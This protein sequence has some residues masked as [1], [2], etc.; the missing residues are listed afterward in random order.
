VT[1]DLA[2]PGL[3]GLPVGRRRLLGRA[4]LLLLSRALGVLLGVVTTVLIAKQLG[5]P[6]FGTFALGLVLL[7]L[8]GTITD[9][10]LSALIVR[11]SDRRPDLQRALLVWGERVRVIAGTLV[12]VVLAGIAV[13]TVD[14]SREQLAVVAIV[15]ALPLQAWSLGTAVM[16]Q[17]LLLSRISGLVLAQS[18]VYVVVVGA[19]YAA[20]A[21]LLG[22]AVGYLGF[23]AGYAALVS[24]T[25]RRLLRGVGDRLT[26]R[27][28]RALVADAVPLSLSAIV[29]T[30]YY[31]VDSLL[32]YNLSTPQDAGAYAVAYRFLDHAQ[33]IP[34]TLST[35]FL[36][37]LTRRHADGSPVGEVVD[38]YI[39]LSLLVSVPAVGAGMLAAEPVIGIFGSEYGES[40]V[41]L[42][43]LL[44][45]FVPVALG[46]VCGNVAI[47]HRRARSQLIVAVAALILNVALNVA[48]IGRYGARAAAVISVVTELAVAAALF[49]TLRR[50]CGLTFPYRWLARLAATTALA[51]AAGVPLLSLPL[52]AAPVFLAV[53][54]AAG[55]A[56][57]VVTRDELQRLLRRRGAAAAS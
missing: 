51:A 42:R 40:V 43:L 56:L 23:A 5:P 48:L 16:Q 8:G 45:A 19:L 39:R 3:S 36:P 4:A 52:L 44:P 29:I 50:P 55:L 28:F 9:L 14:G 20:N 2:P 57:G 22:F 25:A 34:L 17:R 30:V 47:V 26:W 13:A 31:K 49:W 15:A 24:V 41:L 53:F 1:T 6:A 27:H 12:A 10:G 11:E 38:E 21:S 54:A 18:V 7:Q 35:L 33:L 46:Y 32:V 37:L